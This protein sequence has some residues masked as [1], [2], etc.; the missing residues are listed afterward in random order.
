MRAC[1]PRAKAAQAGQEAGHLFEAI[2][3]TGA[4][5]Q[6]AFHLRRLSSF[7]LASFFS[8]WGGGEQK[9]HLPAI[10]QPKRNK[11]YW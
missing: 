7:E 8:S 3:F 4:K 5:K 2:S 6:A 11:K 10:V 1:V 9:N